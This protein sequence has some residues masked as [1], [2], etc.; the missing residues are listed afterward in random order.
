M[1]DISLLFDVARSGSPS[2]NSETLIKSQLQAIVDNINA[3]PFE[4]KVKV[5]QASLDNMRAQIEGITKST[6]AL[7][8]GIAFTG[9]D[10]GMRAVSSTAGEVNRNLKAVATSAQTVKATL[11]ST[12]VSALRE[13]LSTIDGIEQS[14][15]TRLAESLKSVNGELTSM[16]ARWEESANGEQKILRLTVGAKNELGQSL[17]YLISFDKKTGE[18]SR[19]LVDV[20][21][22]FK[23]VSAEAT[24]TTKTTKQTDDIASKYKA[25]I[26]VIKEYY[27]LLTQKEKNPALANDIMLSNG[28]WT[29]KSGEF[30]NFAQMLDNVY[31]SFVRVNQ[32]S[33]IFSE[34]QRKSLYDIKTK[35]V[36]R[37]RT[38][39]EQVANAEK[40]AAAARTAKGDKSNLARETSV[41]NQYNSALST[42][43][44]ALKNWTAAENSKHESSRAAYQALKSAVDGAQSAKA[45]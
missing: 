36:N 19:K 28:A 37:Y 18:V 15:A 22:S 24:K 4:I 35:E 40:R 6:G 9:I 34:E 12:N 43:Q 42:C 2:E 17:Q 13:A 5:E 25:A 11:Q 29:S 30:A 41:V 8:G 10:R 31:Q 16:K 33:R 39:I 3:K 1:A 32:E 27:A 14:D 7:G 44:R 38:A 20:A 23:T 45:A 21:Q 26:A